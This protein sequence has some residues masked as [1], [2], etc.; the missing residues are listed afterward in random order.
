[1]GDHH[2]TDNSIAAFEI[3]PDA[4]SGRHRV[5]SAGPG[6]GVKAGVVAAATGALLVGAGQ[7]GAGTAAAAPA[8]QNI[9]GFEIPQGL[10]P[11]G[12]EIPAALSNLGLPPVASI[13][14][15]ELPD[16]VAQVN[17]QVQQFT[18]SFSP[19][20]S[21]GGTV[22]PVSG[23]LTSTFGNRWGAHHGGLDIAA[24]IGTPVLA[25]AAGQVID[26]GPA[27][28]FGLWVRIQ[29]DDGAVT[30][31]GHVNDYQVAVGQRVAAG[32]QIATVGNRGQSTG[33]HLHFEVA[34]NGAKVDPAIWLKARGVAVTWVDNS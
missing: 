1:M 7:M 11:E 4:A 3:D 25:A 32:Q 24:P 31:Y 26:A 23:T 10:L 6:A 19:V 13:E 2:R 30:T 18:G 5:Q 34:E 33:P 17:A 20:S 21:N 12:I 14:V 22:Q 29:H 8:T 16:L 28:G 27:S 15:P 9:A